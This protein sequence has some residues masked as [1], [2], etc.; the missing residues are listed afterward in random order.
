ME[1]LTAEPITVEM[2]RSSRPME[3]VQPVHMV[4]IQTQA[5]VNVWTTT[6]LIIQSAMEQQSALDHTVHQGDV[7]ATKSLIHLALV[8]DVA[9]TKS[10]TDQE[11]TVFT[12]TPGLD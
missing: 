11:D 9:T 2:I 7:Q 6:Q 12:L 5:K 3:P 10:Q 4:N 8:L 1:T